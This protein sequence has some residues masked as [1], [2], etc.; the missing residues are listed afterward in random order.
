[1]PTRYELVVN[2]KQATSSITK[3]SRC[4]PFPVSTPRDLK[5]E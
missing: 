3:I 2:L 4:T 5:W 1:M